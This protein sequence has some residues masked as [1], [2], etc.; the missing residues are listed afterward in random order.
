MASVVH[1]ILGNTFA[2]IAGKI[3]TACIALLTVKIL[4]SYFTHQELGAYGTVYSYL[5]LFGALADMGIYTLVLREMS[6]TSADSSQLYST[7]VALRICTTGL[8]M[9]FAVVLAFLIP[10]YAESTIPLGVVIASIGTFFILMSGTVS[11]VLQYA[12]KMKFYQYSL[13][14]GKIAIFLGVLL[15]TQ[16][17]Y[18]RNDDS[19]T[20]SP[21]VQTHDISFYLILTLGTLGAFIILV[22]TFWFAQ[23][24]LRLQWSM[25]FSQMKAMFYEALPFGTSMVLTTFYFQMGMLFLYWL[26]PSAENGVCLAEFCKEGESAKY[27]IALRMMEVLLY[28]P[29]FFMTSLL[30]TMTQSVQNHSLHHSKRN[31]IFSYGFLFLV[32]MGLP[33]AVGGYFLSTP[34]ASILGNQSLLASGDTWGSDTAFS[35]LSIALFFAFINYFAL[36]ALIA[37]NK[38]KQVLWIHFLVVGVGILLNLF[39]IPRFGLVGAGITTL[40]S[41]IILSFSLYG[42]LLWQSPFPLL[43]SSIA[44]VFLATGIMGGGLWIWTDTI[45]HTLG[46]GGGFVVLTG[47]SIIIFGGIL[48]ITRFFSSEMKAFFRK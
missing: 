47:I 18:P 24:H 2:Q 20:E 40:I 13:I 3:I 12:L 5:A 46:T 10:Q 48:L 11:V 41:E 29:V 34:M 21:F 45:L 17:L 28:F 32:V 30:P 37:L 15:I 7:G 14:L 8:A 38:Q 42:L 36:Y 19:F 23:Q 43:W 1:K 22:L 4:S 9:V 35:F 33:I 16:V 27:I 25:N 26:L 39:F 31:M 6:K 44:K